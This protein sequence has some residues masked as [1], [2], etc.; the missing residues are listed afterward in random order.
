MDNHQQI[1]LLISKLKKG[2]ERTNE[3][4]TGISR[5][6]KD[7]LLSDLRILYEMV[8]DLEVKP[9]YPKKNIPKENVPAEI[10]FE[11]VVGDQK[12]P[13]GE[14][15]EKPEAPDFVAEKIKPKKDVKSKTQ[16]TKPQQFTSDLFSA[17]KTF[18]DV[19]K[20]NGDNSL[21]AKMQKNHISDIKA[22]IGINEKFLFIN[23]IFK[24]EMAAYSKAIDK[25][26]SFEQYHEAIQ[27]VDEIK[28]LNKVDNPDAWNKLVDIIKRKFY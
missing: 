18:A 20:T 4:S 24:G 21:S 26:N 22:A 16:K 25:I 2:W 14:K 6:D 3:T 9:T 7:I 11:I 10:D 28:L 27:F 15:K 19:Y 8:S 23:D 12:L 5:I 17:S 13:D 1:S